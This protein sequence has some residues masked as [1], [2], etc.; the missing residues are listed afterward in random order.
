MNYRYKAKHLGQDKIEKGVIEANSQTEAAQKLREQNL[1]ALN[2]TEEKG[3]GRGLTLFK[4]KRVP[5]K[6]KIIFSRQ[7]AV[8]IKAGLPIVKAIDAL[9]KQTENQYF[10]EILQECIIGIKGGSTL[11]KTLARYPKVFPDIYIAVITAGEQTGQLSEVLTNLAFQQE[12]DADLISKIKSAMIYPSVILASLIGVAVLIVVFV[13]P[14][15][16][17]IFADAG[18]QLPLLTRIL[19]GTSKFTRSYYYI[20]LAVIL[21]LIYGARVWFRTSSGRAFY[22]KLKI[23]VPIFGPLTKKVYMARFSRTFAMLTKANLPIL[24]SIKIVRNTIANVH[25]QAA[26]ERVEKH[27]ESGRPLSWALEREKLFPP[28]VYQLVNLGEQSGSM[29]DVLLEVANFYD[30]EVDTTSK[31]LSTLLE[32]ILLI[33]MGIGVGFVVAAVLGP[34]YGLVQNF[35]G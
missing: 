30:D 1:L 4:S 5:L 32:P 6:E 9:S 16:E 7:L 27:V 35:G 25:Y 17:G 20:E 18:S 33:L 31:N 19:L 28:M 14:S 21:S 24:S 26:F 15:L 22:D 3:T 13:I 2:I 29:E 10:K 11:S 34:I 23:K 12:K 8:M